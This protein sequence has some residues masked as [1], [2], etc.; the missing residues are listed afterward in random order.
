[1]MTEDNIILKITFC[2]KAFRRVFSFQR[3]LKGKVVADRDVIVDHAW[4]WVVNVIS[5][6]R[7]PGGHKKLRQIS[8]DCLQIRLE[9]L[10][11][12]AY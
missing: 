4:V 7:R 12:T 11:S 2:P 10:Q 5:L 6:H 9:S 8:A 1:M 3:Q